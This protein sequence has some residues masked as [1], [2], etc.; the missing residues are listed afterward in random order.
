MTTPE[1]QLKTI[2]AS[3]HVLSFKTKVA[4]FYVRGPSFKE[5]HELFGSQYDSL[6]D[7]EDRLGE[8]LIMNGAHP[9]ISLSDTLKHSTNVIKEF[10]E[11]TRPV[12]YSGDYKAHV[13][14]ILAGNQALI[15][16]IG[17]VKGIDRVMDNL[18]ADFEAYFSKQIWFLGTYI[19]EKL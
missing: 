13:S 18:L 17:S 9:C 8:Y 19:K 15:D 12:V 7:M 16:A 3:I 1:Q 5:I 4:H 6:T 14:V 2:L 11:Q 10:D